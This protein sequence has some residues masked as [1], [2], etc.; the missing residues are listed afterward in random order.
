VARS[1]AAAAA[2]GAEPVCRVL[3]YLGTPALVDDLL[4]SA[5]VSLVRQA[6][7]PRFMQLMNLGGFGMAAWDEPSA[8]PSRPFTYR[9]AGVPMFDRNLKALCEKVRAR[10]LVAHVRG[11]IYEPTE[12]VGPQ[13]VHPF[14]FDGAA[15]AL[16]QNGDLFDFGRMRYDLLEYIPPELTARIEG[17]TDTEWFYALCLARLEDPFA[18]CSPD[19]MAAATRDALRIVQQVRAGRGIE[20][21]SPI[22]LVLTDGRSLV[23]TRYVFDYGWYPDDGSFFAGEREHDFTSLWYTL[24]SGCGDGAAAHA[25][26]ALLIASEP[27]TEDTSTW[28]RAPEYSMLVAGYDEHGAIDVRLEE[29]VL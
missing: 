13:N 4:Y 16:A 29:I 2:A 11:V 8:G 3:A 9:T 7:D 15:F 28:L 21:Q 22:N 17:T 5:E 20:T 14:L 24:S 18:P 27:L 23:A 25:T 1:I 19:E 26:S 12:R 6:T 10:A